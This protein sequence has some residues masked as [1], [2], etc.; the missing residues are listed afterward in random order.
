[1]I[2]W[3]FRNLWRFLFGYPCGSVYGTTEC[4][5]GKGH[6]GAHEGQ[7]WSRFG[8]SICWRNENET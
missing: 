7:D 6:L 5:R 8:V 1:M 4:R 3:L 2:T